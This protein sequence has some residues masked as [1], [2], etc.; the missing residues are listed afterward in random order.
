MHSSLRSMTLLLLTSACCVAVASA[1]SIVENAGYTQLSANSGDGQGLSI[2]GLLNFINFDSSLGYLN[3]TTIDWT[4]DIGAQEYYTYYAPLGTIVP[5]TLNW[6]ATATVGPPEPAFGPPVGPQIGSSATA[7]NTSSGSIVEYLDYIGQTIGNP[8]TLSA[9]TVFAGADYSYLFTT[10]VDGY[11]PYEIFQ[12]TSVEL[13][14][15]GSGG[16]G[17]FPTGTFQGFDDGGTGVTVQATITYNYTPVP[18]PRSSIA[19]L[20]IASLG[21]VGIRTRRKHSPTV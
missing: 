4:V 18:E 8:F 3:S 2:S 20:A 19:L 6:T 9:E 5:Y 12:S 11:Y 17:F 10:D 16:L 13:Q 21:I 7:T 15:T 14:D 1:D